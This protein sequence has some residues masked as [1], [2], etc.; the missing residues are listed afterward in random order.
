MIVTLDGRRVE[1]PVAAGATLGG[2]IATVRRCCAENRLLVSIVL[3][4]RELFDD[5]LETEIA[6]ALDDA[7][8]VDFESAERD[9]VI[10]AAL[11]A[12]AEKV[13]HAGYEAVEI[14]EQLNAAATPDALRR[15][16]TLVETWQACRRALSEAGG[17]IGEDLTQRTFDGRSVEAHLN[18]LAGR[19][20]ELRD[21]LTQR[22]FVLIADLLHYELPPLCEHWHKLLQTLAPAR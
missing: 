13:R 17:L 3:N 1:D 18:E 4:G 21:A 2:V 20:G 12:T 22:D 14:A 8:Q 15:I 6:A 5:D 9:G 10:R 11:A 16:G 7:D 19:L